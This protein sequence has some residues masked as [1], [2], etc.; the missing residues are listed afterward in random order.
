ME[1]CQDYFKSNFYLSKF[2]IM[3]QFLSTWSAILA[4]ATYCSGNAKAAYIMYPLTLSIMVVGIII[5]NYYMKV[6][7]K[8]SI[9]LDL[10]IHVIPYLLIRSMK[11][12]PVPFLHMVLFYMGIG[13]IYNLCFRSDVLVNYRNTPW[14]IIYMLFPITLLCCCK[15]CT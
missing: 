14:Y 4:Y 3:Y 7:L 12:Q 11:K 13:V 5:T 6:P 8:V 2:Y 15:G 1:I 9:P 10:L